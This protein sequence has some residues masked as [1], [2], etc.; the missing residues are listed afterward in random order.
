[1]NDLLSDE[2]SLMRAFVGDITDLTSPEGF[3][4]SQL[5]FLLIPLLFLG[6]AITQGS[7]AIAG[8]EEKGT[9]DL[10]MSSPVSRRHVLVHKWAAMLAT[11][12][13]LAVATWV[14]LVVGVAAVGMDISV[15][16]VAEATLSAGFLAMSFGTLALALGA[17]NGRRAFSIAIASVAGVTAYLI[18]ALTPAVEALEPARYISPFHYY[19][20]ANPLENGLHLGHVGVLLLIAAVLYVLATAA[21]ER[22]DLG[23]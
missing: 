9:L 14:G 7:A 8:E 11:I 1:L 2:N 6:F 19:S 13:V 17:A 3:L 18:N 12:I 16:K 20:G 23:V 15:L 4:N 22:R 21:F 10:L 5:F